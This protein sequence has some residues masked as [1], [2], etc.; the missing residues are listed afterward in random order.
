MYTGCG[1]YS[2][3]FAKQRFLPN[4]FMKFGPV[5][6][7][8]PWSSH[9]VYKFW[10]IWATSIP[11]H[12][13]LKPSTDTIL[14]ISKSSSRI[15]FKYRV[16]PFDCMT[17]SVHTHTLKS[18]ICCLDSALWLSCTLTFKRIQLWELQRC[19]TWMGLNTIRKV[20]FKY[21][22]LISYAKALLKIKVKSKCSDPITIYT[23]FF[24]QDGELQTSPHHFDS[25]W[26]AL[27]LFLKKYST[28]TLEKPWMDFHTIVHGL[29]RHFHTLVCGYACSPLHS[30]NQTTAPALIILN[31]TWNASCRLPQHSSSA[32]SGPIS[33]ITITA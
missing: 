4:S 14:E 18:Q 33:P 6:D 10:V 16:M 1:W 32:C 28:P 13:Q 2:Q 19:N 23:Q 29:G 20:P 25:H 12:V 26:T 21:N 5:W 8:C 31:P 30:W 15:L 7:T 3:N 11:L 24:L 9:I 22:V 17:C 27:V